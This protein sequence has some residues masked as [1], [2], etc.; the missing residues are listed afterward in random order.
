MGAP[1]E[2]SGRGSEAEMHFIFSPCSVD[3][4]E[5]AEEDAV[6]EDEEEHA[7]GDLQ[8]DCSETMT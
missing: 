6:E 7:S 2:G 8:S 1:V 4:R 3:G 5:E